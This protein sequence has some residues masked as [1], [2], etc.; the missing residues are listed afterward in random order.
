MLSAVHDRAN[1]GATINDARS[2]EVGVG[3]SVTAPS[4]TT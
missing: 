4:P 2:I 3:V 1:I